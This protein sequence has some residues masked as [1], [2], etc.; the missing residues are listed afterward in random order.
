MTRP[1]DTASPLALAAFELGRALGRKRARL[2]RCVI[3]AGGLDWPYLIGGPPNAPTVVLVHGF[4]ADKDNWLLYAPHF[5]KHFRVIVPDL[6]GFGEH[7]RSLDLDYGIPAQ[8]RRLRQFVDA[9]GISEF[10]IAGNSMG[11]YLALQFAVDY[12]HRLRT[13]T[14]IDNGGVASTSQSPLE[15]SVEAGEN[16]LSVETLADMRRTIALAFHRRVP[17]PKAV[18]RV[19]L[20]DFRTHDDSNNRIFWALAQKGLAGDLDA[21]LAQVDVPTLI[22]WGREDRIIDVS[23]VNVMMGLLPNAESVILEQTGHTPMIE[24]PSATAKHH[25]AFIARHEV[26]AR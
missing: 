4:S 19:M 25:L 8:T 20:N 22:I 14:P 2:R 12:P 3:R 13:L 24:R 21:H 23:C 26:A 16:P 10:H 17:I 6:P 1:D 5:T 7:D 9:L 15:Q 11:G 18:L